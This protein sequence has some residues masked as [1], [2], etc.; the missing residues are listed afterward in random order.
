MHGNMNVKTGNV[1]LPPPPPYQG[2]LPRDK[3]LLFS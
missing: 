1:F 2:K 3:L